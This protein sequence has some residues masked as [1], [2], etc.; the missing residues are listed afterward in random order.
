[1][2]DEI[3]EERKLFSCPSHNGRSDAER[4]DITL[5]GGGSTQRAI[6]VQAWEYDAS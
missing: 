3:V 5:P 4:P 6:V 2:A 1:M